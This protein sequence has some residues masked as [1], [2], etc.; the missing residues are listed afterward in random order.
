MISTTLMWSLIVV[1][2]VIAGV[3]AFEGN[4]PRTLYWVAASL[5]TGAILWGTEAK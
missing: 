3:S 5:L 2:L 1:Y 4:Q